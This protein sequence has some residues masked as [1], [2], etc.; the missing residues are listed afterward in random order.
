MINI[1]TLTR[2]RPK[3]VQQFLQSLY[4]TLGHKEF[5]LTI[6]DDESGQEIAWIFRD[7]QASNLMILHAR[8]TGHNLAMLK[9]L[10]TQA[11]RLRWGM[12]D[13]L[14]LGDSDTM[15]LGGWAQALVTSATSSEEDGFVL[16][17]G[18]N[19]PFLHP[20]P[21]MFISI[22]HHRYKLEETKMLDG[23]SWLMRWA[24]WDSMGG[25]RGTA[26]GPG[27][28]EDSEFCMR[29]SAQG[30]RIGVL[31]PNVVI[32]CGLTNSLG[33]DI[34]GRELLEERIPK[35]VIAE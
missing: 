34:V 23:P 3:L 2:N 11:S 8:N 27:Q 33:K 6:V 21:G 9:N 1:V 16:W 30:G 12:G 32:H 26:P 31:Q 18:Q 35:G 10:G 15:F 4:S 7:F 25:L 29:L 24:T 20:D 13:W 17:G 14:Y 5:N 22:G 19:H 28:S